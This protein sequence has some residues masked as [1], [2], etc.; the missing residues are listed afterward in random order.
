[1]LGKPPHMQLQEKAI[2]E[3]VDIAATLGEL[4]VKLRITL[5]TLEAFQQTNADNVF[6]TG[7]H[8]DN[9]A[10]FLDSYYNFLI[11]SYKQ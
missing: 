1:M 8:T 2:P 10:Y 9:L 5:K 6:N 7:W 3:H 4:E 11:L